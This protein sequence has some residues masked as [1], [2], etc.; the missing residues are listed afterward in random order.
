MLR[1]N[2]I[3]GFSLPSVF[4]LLLLQDPT[5][6]RYVN[7]R[8]SFLIAC[9]KVFFLMFNIHLFALGSFQILLVFY[10]SLCL[11]YGRREIYLLNAKQDRS[12]LYGGAPDSFNIVRSIV[13][14]VFDEF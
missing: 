5:L 10:R 8:I 6:S 7:F 11:V 4:Q 1:S 9:L 2:M 13:F 3:R 14:D 12:H